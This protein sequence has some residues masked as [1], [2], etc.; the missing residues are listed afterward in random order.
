M[1]RLVYHLPN[2]PL[3]NCRYHL[4]GLQGSR[5]Q[6]IQPPQGHPHIITVKREQGLVAFQ[7]DDHGQGFDLEEVQSRGALDRRL[8]LAIMDERVR[9]LGAT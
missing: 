2:Q 3:E 5:D 9:L 6:Y 8:G 1:E 7:I 4:T